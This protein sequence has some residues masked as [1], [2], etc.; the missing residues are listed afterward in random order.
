MKITVQTLLKSTSFETTINI[1]LKNK[2]QPGRAFKHFVMI[3]KQF[4]NKHSI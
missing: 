2:T 1:Y 4:F 3:L